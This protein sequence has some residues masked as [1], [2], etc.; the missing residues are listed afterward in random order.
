MILFEDFKIEQ[1]LFLQRY[2]EYLKVLNSF[3]N[4]IPIL[5]KNTI[6]RYC[7]DPDIYEYLIYKDKNPIGIVIIGHGLNN[8]F[9]KQDLYIQDFYIFPEFQ[10]QHYG[11]KAVKA[12]TEKYFGYDFSLMIL[13]KNTNAVKFWDKVFSQ[14]DYSERFA[15]GKINASSDKCYFKYYLKN[16]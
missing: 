4:S 2:I 1:E 5:D 12:L 11:Y 3:D 6:L 8:T 14:L 15:A 7:A 13:K 9:S 16:E 10:R